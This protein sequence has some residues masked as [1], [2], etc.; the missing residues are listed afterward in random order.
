MSGI[1]SSS[2]RT[3]S[4]EG[5]R[6][7]R[8]PR[9]W[10]D[11]AARL[12]SEFSAPVMVLDAAEQTWTIRAGVASEYGPDAGA[13]A[14]AAM[15]LGENGRVFLWRAA[16]E[17]VVWLA[18]PIGLDGNGSSWAF[19]G[20]AEIGSGPMAG[21]GHA[22]PD[23]A[24]HAW[25]QTVADRLDAES[26]AR[27]P[28]GDRPSRRVPRR[29]AP[30][31]DE[32]IRRLRVS[33]PPDRFQL[34]LTRALRDEL[35][36]AAVAW[37]PANP[38]EPVIVGGAVPD[39]QS[40]SYRG[41]VALGPDQPVRFLDHPGPSGTRRVV[42]VAES[43]ERPIGWLLVVD[44]RDERTFGTAEIEFLRSVASLLVTQRNNA[45]LY[46]DIKELLF[47][48]I[49]ALTSAID[50]KDPY[51]SGHSER[52]ARIAVR[53]GEQLGLPISQRFDL[54]LMGLLHDV[55]K[56]G[57]E[58]NVL[59][60]PGKLTPEEYHAIQ[61]HVM[62]GV[63]I[64]QDL[65]KLNYVLPGVK[66]HHECFDGSGYPDRLAGEQIPF[67]ARILAV[68]DSYDAM[69]SHRPYRRRLSVQQID[70]IFRAGIGKQWDP[71][72]VEAL[73]ACRA[74]VEMIRSKGVGES[75]ITAVDD[76]LVREKVRRN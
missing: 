71:K 55:G 26:S 3:L 59:K 31:L 38:Q 51:T 45:R 16:V 73:F 40:E 43:V 53:I 61:K 21:W 67:P 39:L 49:R 41:L 65:K 28:F 34:Q 66:H 15:G 54:Y 19:V 14:C 58:D 76:A 35:G 42:I 62:I 36:V 63:R 23:P 70:E 74:D 18:L 17:G 27:L 75:V 44:P 10:S 72:V 47:G 8:A 56:I 22:C 69:S 7:G 1:T 5:P 37:V 52:V 2:S 4:A 50:A 24:L 57:V 13:A 25:G 33:D 48:I 6:R 68:A 12:G 30:L 46:G 11:L 20:F 32:F 60:K 29:T 9:D 64:L